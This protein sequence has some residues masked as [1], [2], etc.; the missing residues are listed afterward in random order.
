MKTTVRQLQL[1][2]SF[3][4]FDPGE[5]DGLWGPKTEGTVR[6]FQEKNGLTADGEPGPDTQK[7]L[8]QAVAYGLPEAEGM[9]KEE[10]FWSEIRD[11]A[12]A[13]FGC[14]CGFYHEP[15]C[16]GFPAE[17]DERVVRLAQQCRSHFGRPG[18]I[19]SGLRCRQH[20]ADSGGVANSQHMDG[21]ACDLRIEGVS[22]GE[23]L[24]YI[25][26]L[27]GVRYA[28]AINDTNVQFDVSLV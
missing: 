28:Y 22:A 7:A 19:V 16:D 6:A 25:Q 15:Y 2:L 21:T 11:F 17:M 12:R 13:E 23:L 27:P 10:G 1:L 9:E 20:N 18:H 4:G 5:A 14:K 26:T 24:G 8:R 3:L